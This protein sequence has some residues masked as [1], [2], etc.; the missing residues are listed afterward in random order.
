V[1]VAEQIIL[2]HIKA[3]PVETE[4]HCRRDFS[5]NNSKVYPVFNYT[6]PHEDVWG[7]GGIVLCILNFGTG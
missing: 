1:L 5:N 6:A 4:N 3:C 7:S 2:L